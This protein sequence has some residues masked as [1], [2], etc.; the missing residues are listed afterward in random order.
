M[1]K[2]H[3]LFSHINEMIDWSTNVDISSLSEPIT[4]Y[5]EQKNIDVRRIKKF[6]AAILR[7][8][9]DIPT[10]IRF[11]KGNYTG[12]YRNVG[13]TVKILTESGCDPK[14]VGEVKNLLTV[15]CPKNST[16]LLHV[17]IFW[18]FFNMAITILLKII[19]NKR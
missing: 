8:D 6:L 11:L 3:P 18:I 16:R 4:N 12:E 7:F 17:K 13:K 14:I 19:W 1:L 2:L 5:A 15:G 10:L 9:F